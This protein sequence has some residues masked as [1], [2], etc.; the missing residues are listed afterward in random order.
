MWASVD[1]SIHNRPPS[2]AVLSQPQ[3]S[4]PRVS[5]G[6]DTWIRWGYPPWCYSSSLR[7][8]TR[9]NHSS[10]I[11]QILYKSSISGLSISASFLKEIPKLIYP[12]VLSHFSLRITSAF[13][14]INQQCLGAI[15]VLISATLS[16]QKADYFIDFLILNPYP[17]TC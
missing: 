16:C 13:N 8:V 4:I 6:N 5:V 14:G 1:N 7:T 11:Q 15:D 12:L 17:R 2:S 9:S 3:T 10:A